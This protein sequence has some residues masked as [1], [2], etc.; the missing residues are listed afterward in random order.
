[1]FVFK[2]SPRPNTVA[3]KHLV[4][5]VPD[6]IKKERNNTMLAVQN[7][8]AHEHHQNMVGHEFSI[9]CEGEAKI[10]RETSLGLVQLR[11]AQTNDINLTGRTYGDHI[12]HFRGHND[13]IGTMVRVKITEARPLSLGGVLS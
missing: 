7:N 5:N 4:D 6:T 2:Y 10:D 8:I 3:F 9:L 11:T 1:V 13:M 12:V